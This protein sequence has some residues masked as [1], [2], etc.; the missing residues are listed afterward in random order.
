MKGTEVL[1]AVGGIAL[2]YFIYKSMESSKCPQFISC[3]TPN[4]MATYDAE[5]PAPPEPHPYCGNMPKQCQGKTE[6][7]Y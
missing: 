2:V 1:L 7:L 5:H 3:V 6:I 4:P